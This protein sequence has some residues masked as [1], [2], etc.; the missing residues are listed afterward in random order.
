MST[1]GNK[2]LRCRTCTWAV[3]DPCRAMHAS[4]RIALNRSPLARSRDASRSAPAS[5]NAARRARRAR[6]RYAT[7][8]GRSILT[9]TSMLL[10]QPSP[11]VASTNGRI[12]PLKS[13]PTP[14][15]RQGTRVR[16]RPERRMLRA[17]RTCTRAR[18]K[19]APAAPVLTAH[20]RYR[21]AVT[22]R[23]TSSEWPLRTNSAGPA[24]K[25]STNG[26]SVGRTQYSR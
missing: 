23:M 19:R 3:G 6:V 4:P 5:G 16:R 25:P 17:G 14:W 2:H 18:H 20:T 10:T 12:A 22:R 8:R 24:I 15:S 21:Q 26:T 13:D 11:L 9:E 1:D 7:P